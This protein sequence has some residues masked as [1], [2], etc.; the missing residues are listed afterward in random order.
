LTYQRRDLRWRAGKR[1]R[2]EVACP[3]GRISMD[4]LI[5]YDVSDRQPEV[6]AAMLKK[7]YADHWVVAT[8]QY[9]LPDTTLWKGNLTGPSA[10]MQDLQSVLLTL[11]NVRL[12]RAVAVP[13]DVWDAVPG[14]PHG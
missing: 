11:R 13:C 9:N 4:V 1:D 14:D 5:T 10:A 3:T 8:K 7:G 6:K 12:E 2:P